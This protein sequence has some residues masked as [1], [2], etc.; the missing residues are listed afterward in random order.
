MVEPSEFAGIGWRLSGEAVPVIEN[1][2]AVPGS[3]LEPGFHAFSSPAAAEHEKAIWAASYE[4]LDSAVRRMWAGVG[5]ASISEED[6]AYLQSIADRRRPARTGGHHPKITPIGQVS[7]RLTSRFKPR[8]HPRSPDRQKSRERSRRLAGSGEL[9]PVVRS[10]YPQGQCAVLTVISLEIRGDGNGTCEFPVDK[11]AALAGVCRTTAQSALHEAR[12]LGHLTVEERPRPGR[13]NLTNVIRLALPEWK[14]WAQ[15]GSFSKGTI[16]SNFVKKSSPT[17]TRVIEK[18]NRS[19]QSGS[20]I[21]GHNRTS[22]PIIGESPS[23][24]GVD[25]AWSRSHRLPGP[26]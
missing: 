1:T 3:S 22:G 4:Q 2:N 20:E 24:V 25:V 23:V 9:P 5:D 14:K 18:E 8:Q 11:I 13:K 7:G 15:R 10:C 17:K 6:A 16:G 19:R 12:R 21:I 26:D